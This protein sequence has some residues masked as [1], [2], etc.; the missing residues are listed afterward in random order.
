MKHSSDI[1]GPCIFMYFFRFAAVDPGFAEVLLSFHD[2]W[3]SCVKA[4][5]DSNYGRKHN[6]EIYHLAINIFM[7]N[8]ICS[9]VKSSLNWQCSIAI[10]NH[11]RVTQNRVLRCLSIGAISSA[12]NAHNCG[13]FPKD[14]S[15]QRQ[16]IALTGRFLFRIY[17]EFLIFVWTSIL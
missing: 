11:H 1:F 6:N 15:H 16:G 7:E 17:A 9:I 5:R 14:M 13:G 4:G 12:H 2:A 8:C 3:W 10:L